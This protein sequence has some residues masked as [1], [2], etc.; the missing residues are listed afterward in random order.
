[1]QVDGVCVHYHDALI[2]IVWQ[3]IGN[4]AGQYQGIAGFQLTELGKKLGQCFLGYFRTLSVD[5]RFLAGLHLYIDA[6]KS[7]GQMDEIR[8][9]A[10]AMLLNTS[11]NF[12]GSALFL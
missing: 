8:R 2:D 10:K 1:M 3:R 12:C 9:A 6:G 5:F 11:T 7:L 4:A